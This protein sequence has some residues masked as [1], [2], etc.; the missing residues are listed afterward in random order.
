MAELIAKEKFDQ[1]QKEMKDLR[2]K[3]AEEK[4]ALKE[5][6]R[7]EREGNIEKLKIKNQAVKEIQIKCYAYNKFGKSVRLESTILDDIVQVAMDANDMLGKPED[8]ET[9]RPE[10]E[11]ETNG[12]MQEAMIDAG[13]R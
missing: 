4:K 1:M 12:M 9:D 3:V 13:S 5:A 6:T 8:D 2:S 7:K 10:P 11:P